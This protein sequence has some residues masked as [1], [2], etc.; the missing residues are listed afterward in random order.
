MK[1]IKDK[2]L[3]DLIRRSQTG[4]QIA[5]A[6][7]FE[8]HKNLVYKTAY[9]MIGN[10]KEAEDALQEIFIKVHQSLASYQPSKA[11]FTTWLYRITVNYCLN[12]RRKRRPFL[13]SLDEV[14]SGSLV[15]SDFSGRHELNGDHEVQ[16]AVED[17]SEKLRVAVI[18]RY[19]WEL[20]YVEIVQILNI[21]V[22]TVRSRL[23]LALKTLRKTLEKFPKFDPSSQKETA[24]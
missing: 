16:Q 11:A 22:G 23:N 8:Q 2:Q 10:E 20:P 7:L 15:D 6:V 14:F 3:V 19:Y 5:F 1:N 13:F 24:K 18:L 21:P 4:D 17:L 12:H 9:L